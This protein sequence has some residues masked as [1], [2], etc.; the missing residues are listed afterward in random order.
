MCQTFESDLITLHGRV[1]EVGSFLT[2]GRRIAKAL[3]SHS[4]TL[5]EE[6]A[7]RCLQKEPAA[8]KREKTETYNAV[9]DS[10]T[11]MTLDP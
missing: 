4:S 5:E 10:A 1:E 6:G 7:G 3:S 11:D 2:G 9:S 8:A